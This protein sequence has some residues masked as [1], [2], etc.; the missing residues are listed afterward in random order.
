MKKHVKRLLSIL[1]AL[2][3]LVGL[4]LP[5]GV[6]PAFAATGEDPV[7]TEIDFT[8]GD[9]YLIGGVGKSVYR[10]TGNTTDPYVVHL[11]YFLTEIPYN[12]QLI[13]KG[14]SSTVAS[15][16]NVFRVGHHTMEVAFTYKGSFVPAITNN[17]KNVGGAGK[18]YIWNFSITQGGV[19]IKPKG[20]AYGSV[21]ATVS[22]DKTL[23]QYDW[24]QTLDTDAP[25]TLYDFTNVTRLGIGKYT[26]TTS[27]TTYWQVEFEYYLPEATTSLSYACATGTNPT[28]LTGSQTMPTTAGHHKVSFTGYKNAAFYPRFNAAAGTQLYV[29]NYSVKLISGGVELPYTYQSATSEVYSGFGEY[30]GM[31]SS[32]DWAKYVGCPTVTEITF[33]GESG[34]ITRWSP[35]PFWYFGG[36]SEEN[37]YTVT[38]NYYLPKA[39]DSLTLTSVSACTT[40][41]GSGVMPKTPGAHSVMWKVYSTVIRDNKTGQFVPTIKAPAGTEMYIWNWS[42]KLNGAEAVADSRTE[43]APGTYGTAGGYLVDYDWYPT[44]DDSIPMSMSIATQPNKTEYAIGDALDTAGLSLSVTDNYG[45]T[46]TVTEGFT[47]SGFD[48]ATAGEKTVTV[49][50]GGLTATFTVTV[51]E[52]IVTEIIFP[53][54]GDS[55]TSTWGPKPGW[56]FGGVD[57]ATAYTVTFEYFLPQTVNSLKFSAFNGAMTVSGSN[58]MS[59]LTGH[60]TITWTAYSTAGSGSRA[61]QFIPIITAPVGTELYVWNWS[62]TQNGVEATVKDYSGEWNAK[63]NG[64]VGDYLSTYDWYDTMDDSIPMSMSIA[65]Q[66]TK[67]EYEIGDALDTAGLSL[68]V[69]DNYGE[70]YTVTEGFTTSGFDSATAGEKTVTV[71]YGGLTATFTV[72]V[73]EPTVTEIIFPVNGDSATSTWG[74]KPGWYFGGVDEATAYTVTFEYFLP[75]AVASLKFNAFNGATTVSGSNEMNTW[76]GHHTITWT[77]YSTAGSGSRAGQFIPIITAPVGTE[78]YVWNWSVTRNGVEATVK[79]YSGEWNAKTNGTVGDY[80]STYDW[81]PTMDDFEPPVYANHFDF[82]NHELFDTTTF[83]SGENTTYKPLFYAGGVSS[84][85]AEG[86]FRLSFD[87]YMPEAF[88]VYVNNANATDKHVPDD[89]TG[90]AYL[91]QGRH[92]FSAT[93]DIT[94]FDGGANTVFGFATIYDYWGDVNSDGVKDGYQSGNSLFPKDLYVWNF[95]LENLDT[96]AVRATSFTG[97]KNGAGMNCLVNTKFDMNT[98]EMVNESVV[99]ELDYTT[100]PEYGE[101]GFTTG[102]YSVY[103]PVKA[104]LTTGNAAVEYTVSFD[105]Y[106]P[107]TN[108]EVSVSLN[109]Y[110]NPDGS[111][112]LRNIAAGENGDYGLEVGRHKFMA[113]FTSDQLSK[114]LTDLSFVNTCGTINTLTKF[115]V[116]N[117]SLTCTAGSAADAAKGNYFYG[118]D[119]YVVNK[120]GDLSD[121]AAINTSE[122]AVEELTSVAEL[123]MVGTQMR[124]DYALRFI[125]AIKGASVTRNSDG[126]A[127][128]TGATIT[129]GGVTYTVTGAG[130]L[131]A[132]DVRIGSVPGGVPDAVMTLE[133]VGGGTVYNIPAAKLQ[134]ETY[135]ERYLGKGVQGIVFTGVIMN[136][137]RANWGESLSARSYVKYL[138]E[139][140]VEQVFYGEVISRTLNETKSVLD[141]EAKSSADAD[142]E[143]QAQ[144]MKENVLNAA[145][146]VFSAKT[147][148]YVDSV[149]GSDANDGLTPATAWKT[150]ANVNDSDIISRN[151]SSDSNSVAVYFKRGGEYRGRV[152]AKS[153]TYFGAYCDCEDWADDHQCS[154]D[155]P[156]FTTSLLNFRDE[157]AMANAGISWVKLDGFD[158]RWQLVGLGDYYMSVENANSNWGNHVANVY[159]I[160]YDEDGNETVISST[161]SA[162]S[163]IY[164]DYEFYQPIDRT[165]VDETV[166]DVRLGDLFINLPIGVEPTDFDRIEIPAGNSCIVGQ[167][168]SGYDTTLLN[169]LNDRF[170]GCTIDNLAVKYVGYH[171]IS[172]YSSVDSKPVKNVTV[173]N[174]EIG[175]IGGAFH[176][177]EAYADKKTRL[178]NGIEFYGA[179]NDSSDAILVQ[180][181]WIYQCYDAGY[182]NQ[183]VYNVAQ[184]ITV[185]EN[186]IEYCVYSIEI[187]MNEEDGLMKNCHYDN[188]IMRFAGYGFE[189]D[190]RPT[191]GATDVAISHV[192]FMFSPQ[193]CEDVTVNNN[194]FDTSLVSLI[195]VAYPNSTEMN[196]END[197]VGSAYL[198]DYT[199]PEIKGNSYYQGYDQKSVLATCGVK[200]EDTDSQWEFK[201]VYGAGSQAEMKASVTA[202][203]DTAAEKVVFYK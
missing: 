161:M 19:E 57:E 71:T 130:I 17:D 81:Y 170:Y 85:V 183:G 68:S 168:T 185:T 181:N 203:G 33:P 173:T 111:S 82:D 66:P 97:N 86:Q 167:K 171:G 147:S 67:I 70:T 62:V 29:W 43:A 122:L 175:W 41:D 14:N 47:T 180:N 133:K 2:T 32:Y 105:Y 28:L 89:A 148:Y 190:N 15:G 107:E 154:H 38:F 145:D 151:I 87:Y 123:D 158:N 108:K 95:R 50:Y 61:G 90:S 99:N 192:N 56:Y 5:A 129:I 196:T 193:P 116:W 139:N 128:Y 127:D 188:N 24:A 88:V 141:G 138:D 106:L 131:F 93:F 156:L 135:H 142:V 159:F 162:N 200:V 78:L 202:I 182:T 18:L 144:A 27:T 52:S 39:V 174:C 165:I 77:A 176:A 35:K 42:V 143:A 187:W 48:S 169:T 178:G 114:S 124:K 98:I 150:F 4:V 22:S 198:N 121:K 201:N 76:A 112:S 34:A 30:D 94:S 73:R 21:T 120:T 166:T 163:A 55:A 54:N 194:I 7:V 109:Y 96:G 164:G 197:G 117:L 12:L 53:V 58:A 104:G 155:K 26:T 100:A 140:G 119:F 91:Q 36:D 115:Y 153:Y 179:C 110:T 40:L 60:H 72:T 65:T 152:R 92:T 45:E 51:N 136:M 125:A 118:R 83:L 157:V 103:Y 1:T 172:F 137:P 69:T 59:N 84:G 46:Y 8:S 134:A 80:L 3:L 20:D 13:G 191:F 126:T 189:V 186:L 113:K 75:E 10:D 44:M 63:T 6:I 23:S 184:N 160:T 31:L 146:T 79:D 149:N 177:G 49:T 132:R 195:T 9:T 37:H 25:V 16:D 74:P 101:E 11:E 199:G 64:T 102:A